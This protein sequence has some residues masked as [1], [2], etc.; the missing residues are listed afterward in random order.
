MPVSPAPCATPRCISA[1][2]KT[3]ARSC[4]RLDW[5][6]ANRRSGSGSLEDTAKLCR[7]LGDTIEEAKLPLDQ[8]KLNDAIGQIGA[9]PAI[10]HVHHRS[11]GY[12]H[13]DH[14]AGTV[15]AGGAI[16]VT[17]VSGAH[18]PRIPNHPGFGSIP[19]DPT[20]PRWRQLSA[21]AAMRS[22]PQDGARDVASSHRGNEDR[23]EQMAGA[24]D[25][26]I[27]SRASRWRIRW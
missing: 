9:A 1:S 21:N 18:A 19:D 2:W 6:P 10:I 11:L 4:Q 22:L 15:G 27:R 25:N 5:C 16:A 13:R 20:C 14:R 3:P 26:G 17:L 23:P 8:A 24:G 12:P 7:S